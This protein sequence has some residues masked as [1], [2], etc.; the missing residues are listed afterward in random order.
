MGLDRRVGVRDVTPTSEQPDAA[1][2]KRE[3]RLRIARSRRRID[4][5]LRASR[6]EAGELLSWR[7]YVT[8]YPLPF[9]AGALGAGILAAVSFRPG[10][11]AG[12]LGRAVMRGAGQHLWQ[13]FQADV[14][15]CWAASGRNSKP[16]SA[17]A[18]AAS[19]RE[20]DR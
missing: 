19:E 6:A 17:E 1:H 3:L 16:A 14:A 8:R 12:W 13:R 4:A 10:R 18:S 2:Q 5:R 9:L 11:I 20:K 7:T 15:A